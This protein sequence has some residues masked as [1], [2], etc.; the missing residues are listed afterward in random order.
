MTKEEFESLN[1]GDKVVIYGQRLIITHINKKELLISA[2]PESILIASTPN[3]KPIWY[4]YENCE[5]VVEDKLV[6]YLNKG[7]INN[8]TVRAQEIR[9]ICSEELVK[10]MKFPSFDEFYEIWRNNNLQ[11]AYKVFITETKRLNQ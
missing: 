11:D 9:K 2:C 10:D 6:E 8:L 7:Y 1:V 4:R 5:L 3:D